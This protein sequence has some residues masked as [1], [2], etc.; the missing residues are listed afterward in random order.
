MLCPLFADQASSLGK[1]DPAKDKRLLNTF[2]A[3]ACILFCI[4]KV[5]T[6]AKITEQANKT[7]PAAAVTYLRRH[8]LDGALLNDFNW[9]GYLI[10]NL[11]QQRIFIDTR[12]DVFEQT[13][14]YQNYFD[15]ISLKQPIE[16]YHNGELRYALFPTKSITAIALSHYPNWKVVYQ[17]D[18]AMLL[19]RLQ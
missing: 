8:P 17:D 11:P 1:D 3:A 18:T 6:T 4:Y 9:G 12:T 19:H 14:L 5:P 10:W 2:L 7:Y 16:S 15:L 13:G